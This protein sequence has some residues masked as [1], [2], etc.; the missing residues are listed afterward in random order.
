MQTEGEL[1]NFHNEILRSF[2]TVEK[3][4]QIVSESMVAISKSFDFNALGKNYVESTRYSTGH[5]KHFVDK[6]PQNSLH[7]GLINKALPNAKIVIL[8]RHPI[9]V[10]Y[11]V[12]KQ[13]FTNIYQFSYDLEELANYYVH[14]HKLMKHWQKC[15]PNSVYTI[16]YENIIEDLE[17]ETQKLLKF[18]NLEWDENCLNFHKNKQASSTASSSQVRNGLYSS[19]V[20]LWKNYEQQLSPLIDILQSNNCLTDWQ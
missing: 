2:R 19:S 16:R 15:L 4:Q 17:G 10:C 8:E 3:N 5:K 11:A 18:L 9:D 1:N 12:F 14:H 13:I 20:G 6:F 7:V